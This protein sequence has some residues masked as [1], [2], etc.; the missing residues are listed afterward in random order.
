MVHRTEK[1]LRHSS[2][3]A[4]KLTRLPKNLRDA[5]DE[6]VRREVSSE[7]SD[8]GQQLY[9]VLKERGL[10]EAFDEFFRWSA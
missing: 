1:T 7:K 8:F 10:E 4:R 2:L 3:T 6:A 5:F 9:D